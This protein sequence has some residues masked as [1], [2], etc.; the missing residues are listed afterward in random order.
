MSERT[1]ERASDSK[2]RA[3]KRDTHAGVRYWT[4]LFGVRLAILGRFVVI[5]G[6]RICAASPQKWRREERRKVSLLTL[7]IARSV[8]SCSDRVCNCLRD[9]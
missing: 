1:D 9:Y 3:V 8:P 6:D 5:D 4:N 7:P 2:I